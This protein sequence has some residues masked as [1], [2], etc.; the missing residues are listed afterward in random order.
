[1]PSDSKRYVVPKSNKVERLHT[2]ADRARKIAS[3][4]SQ[5]VAELFEM[6]AQLCE[7]NALARQQKR[8]NHDRGSANARHLGFIKSISA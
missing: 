1:M 3:Q 7:R 5:L 8:R 6:H 4:S 2:Q